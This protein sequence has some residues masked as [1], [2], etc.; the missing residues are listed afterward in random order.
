LRYRLHFREAVAHP[1]IKF[2][3]PTGAQSAK[4]R[5]LLFAT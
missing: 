4:W 2:V 3:I 1:A 5:D